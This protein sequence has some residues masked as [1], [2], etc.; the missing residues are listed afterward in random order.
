MPFITDDAWT[1]SMYRKAYAAWQ[2]TAPATDGPIMPRD[3]KTARP[4][5]DKLSAKLRSLMAWK[6][7]TEP[8]DSLA[9]NWLRYDLPAD[10]DN[11]APEPALLDTEYEVQ[12]SFPA[13]RR[14]FAPT[15]ERRPDVE[16]RLGVAV[17]GD[18]GWGV[19]KDVPEY[20]TSK[21]EGEKAPV[22]DRKIV[23]RIR[24]LKF[25]NGE[26]VERVPVLRMGKVVM[27]DVRQPAGALIW[28]KS[29]RTWRRP[30]E[31][32]RG[33]KNELPEV[34]QTVGVGGH[35]QGSLPCPDPY[36]DHEWARDIR[37]LVGK[38]T[39]RVLDIALDA[40]NFREIG[41]AFGKQGKNA[42]RLGK[43]MLLNACAKLD[44]ILAA[45][46]NNAEDVASLHINKL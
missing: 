16:Y 38:D 18:I 24:G 33:A 4:R 21:I 14:E 25:S 22:R 27:D 36:V 37:K 41:E 26:Q 11:A 9:T 34:E 30:S 32:F 20:A 28:Y 43:E 7:A 10:N 31:R 15:S 46:D 44:A 45:N 12:P 42:E 23:T 2:D 13:L 39:A 19:Q 3:A 5:H 6:H 17:G 29:G 40:A 8:D 35:S 1:P